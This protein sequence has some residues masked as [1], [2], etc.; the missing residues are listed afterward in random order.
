MGTVWDGNYIYSGL[1]K[2]KT[3]G[4][5]RFCFV[6]LNKTLNPV[7]EKFLSDGVLCLNIVESLRA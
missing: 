6:L 2:C 5:N 3:N 1:Y 4:E 7:G